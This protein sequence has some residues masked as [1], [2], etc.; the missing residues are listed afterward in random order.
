M[1]PH[2]TFSAIPAAC[3][4]GNGVDLAPPQI[5]SFPDGHM[6]EPE[7]CRW[8]A[9]ATL[10]VVTAGVHGRFYA[11][12][13]GAGLAGCRRRTKKI[14]CASTRSPGAVAQESSNCLLEPQA[15]ARGRPSISCSLLV[16]SSVEILITMRSPAGA[17]DSTWVSLPAHRLTRRLWLDFDVVEYGKSHRFTSNLSRLSPLSIRRSERT[18]LIPLMEP[19]VA[20]LPEGRDHVA[21]SISAV[22]RWS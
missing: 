5:G 18:D 17:R 2:L 10:E 6:A 21:V 3:N 13:G 1:E 15:A 7:Q 22:N 19:D 11:V 14:I 12:A 16:P 9:Q 8:S 20:N 4:Y